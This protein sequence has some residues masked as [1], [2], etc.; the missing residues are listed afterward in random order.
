[1]ADVDWL[2]VQVL[3]V[4][5]S[6][7]EELADLA[8]GLRAELLDVDA[9]SVA[10]LTAEAAPEGAKWLGTVPG[11]LLV[12][13]GTLDG[14]RAV[15]AA[16]H[17]WTSRTGRTVEVS[18]GGDVLK[19]TAVTSQQ[20][21]EIIDA[22]LARHAPADLVPLLQLA[23]HGQLRP[24]PAQR[25]GRQRRRARARRGSGGGRGQPFEIAWHGRMVAPGTD[26]GRVIKRVIIR[27][28]GMAEC[29]GQIAVAGERSREAGPG[30]IRASRVL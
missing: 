30:A 10:P 29:A 1:V 8:G 28:C 9:A 24:H 18:I 3:Q 2:I 23:D 26:I 4:A 20:Q 25:L 5:D 22:W 19:V 6:D 16:V 15:V 14:L 13:F 17:G 21:R 7:T 11:W 12:Q 27:F